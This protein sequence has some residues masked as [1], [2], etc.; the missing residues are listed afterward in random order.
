MRGGQSSFCVLQP[1]RLHLDLGN[2][3]VW[4]RNI[5]VC[6]T[7]VLPWSVFVLSLFVVWCF[8]FCFVSFFFF[9]FDAHKSPSSYGTHF[10]RWFGARNVQILRRRGSL[11]LGVLCVS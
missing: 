4:G 11:V 2:I 8:S 10:A 5:L 7:F 6:H 9:F 3:D 1:L